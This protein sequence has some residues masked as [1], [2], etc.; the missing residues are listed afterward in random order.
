MK[1]KAI[2]AIFLPL[3]LAVLPMTGSAMAE[4][5]A[6]ISALKGLYQR[7]TEIPFPKENPYTPE[8]A[9]LGKALF[10]EPRLSGAKNM[11]CASCHNPSFGW[12]VPV[13]TAVG[14]KNVS[15]SRQAPTVLNAAWIHPFFWDG[16]A[17]SAEA[18]A[19]GPI[20]AE[21]EMNLP[22]D[23]AVKR[24]ESVPDYKRWFKLAFPDK[25]VTG[26][27]ILQALA[28]YER[29]IVAGTS[30]FDEW[31]EGN[32]NAISASAKRGFKLFNTKAECAACH[33]GWMF[34]D[35]SFH[36]IGL[37]TTDIGRAGIEP[38]VT[39]ATHAFKT[40]G[41]RDIALRA[42]FMHHGRIGTLEDVIAHYVSGGI[43]RPSK[44]PLVRP[45][46]LSSDEI[47]DLVAFLES[48]SATR[49][50]VSL[51]VLPN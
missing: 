48:L 7:P 50:V 36:D 29:T 16:R 44:S 13:P 9:A 23:E 28:T 45:L 5:D 49:E 14:A 41:L 18:Q 24:L 32:E 17:D 12:E 35:N 39:E 31:I 34:T 4:P 47:K 20:E 21:L 38:G 40:P 33:S 19:R 26:N 1:A 2:S 11:T 6:D 46:D 15:L 3:S 37:D 30:R 43:D 10:F 22:L 27:T 8:K 25:G 42:P 51:P